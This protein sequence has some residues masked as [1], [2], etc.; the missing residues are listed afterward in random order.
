MLNEISPDILSLVF[1]LRKKITSIYIHIEGILNI[2]IT[3]KYM[4]NQRTHVAG[5][6]QFFSAICCKL[7]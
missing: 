2:F 4:N 7:I 1:V 5:H 3:D 6:L